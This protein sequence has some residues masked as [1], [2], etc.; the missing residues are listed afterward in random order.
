MIV[1]FIFVD[2]GLLSLLIMSLQSG[3]FAFFL[4][5]LKINQL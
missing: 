1:G 4:N 5:L 3:L 2:L